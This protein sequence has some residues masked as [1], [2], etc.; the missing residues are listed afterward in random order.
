MFPELLGA[1]R[2]QYGG[3][4]VQNF[5]YYQDAGDQ[6]TSGACDLSKAGQQIPPTPDPSVRMPYSSSQN[7]VH[8]DSQGDIGQ[9]AARLDAVISSMYANNGNKPIILIGY[10]MGGETIRSFLAYSTQLHDGVATGMVDSVLLMHGVEQGS[11]VANAAPLGG[12]DFPFSGISAGDLLAAMGLPNANRVGVKEFSPTSDYMNWVD[13]NS[14][15]LPAIPM[16]NTWGD[17]RVHTH[18]CT[19]AIFNACLDTPRQSLGDLV[20]MPGTDNPTQTPLLGGERFLPGGASATHYEWAE[21]ADYAWDPEI[22]PLM[23]LVGTELMSA[24]QMHVNLPAHQAELTISDCQTHQPINE[25]TELLRVVTARMSGT[26]YE[27]KP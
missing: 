3:D 21:T 15:S 5:E 4:N 12:L 8:C 25:I 20:L 26:T 16:Y 7:D 22:D 18:I 13:Q 19:L 9:N 17:E 24:P 10:S 1:L 27:C 14:D 11:W 6:D 23:Q 2:N